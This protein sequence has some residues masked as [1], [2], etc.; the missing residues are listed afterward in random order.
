MVGVLSTIIGVGVAWLVTIAE[1]P[2]RKALSWMLVLPLAAPSYIIAYLYTDLLSFSGPVQSAIRAAFDVGPG[3]YWFPQ[4]RSIPGAAIMLSLVLYPYIYLLA[5]ASFASQSRSQFQAARTLGLSPQSAF[6][7]VAL[8]G[9]RPAIA[10]GLAL[11]LM[12]TIADFGVADYFSIPTFSTGI[13]RTW[14]AMG[15]RLAAMKLA[16][17]MLLFVIALL[18]FESLSRRGSVA[19]SDRLSSAAP[20]FKLSA[21][22]TALAIFCCALPIT[23]G[24]I[25]PVA[26]LLN[27][28]LTQ[29]DGQSWVL[30]WSYAQNSIG[31]AS[32]TSVIAVVLALLLVY[33]QR[34]MEA[35][36]FSGHA[37]K[38]GTR[39][40][41]LGYALPGALLAVG[42]LGP[43]GSFDQTITRFSRETFGLSHGLLLTGSITV[44]VYA[45]VVRFLTVSF[46]SINGGIS[47]ISRSMD[48]AAQSLGA[49]PLRVLRQIHFPLLK[50]SLAAG[51]A[52]VFIDVLRELPATLILRPFNFETL[53]TRVYRL[54]SDERLSEAS[55]SALIIV[56]V[57]VIPVVVLNRMKT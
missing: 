50:S 49:T 17:F 32:I 47:K 40:A 7:K 18:A 48:A 23:F 52:L 28:S 26:I 46:N 45:L 15:D 43:L 22:G 33:A 5:R 24:F 36:R 53:A 39:I 38:A 10:G 20:P 21:S 35:N 16:G 14:L 19:S 51:A 8:P 4:I 25:V 56:A 1:F 41:T 11:V 55:T 37:V 34:Q 31:A 44:L 42:L 3:E 29:G 57:S 13:F 54:A 27:F 6:F 9:A 12:E 2:G 30:L